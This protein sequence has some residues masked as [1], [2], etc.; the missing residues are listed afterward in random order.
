MIFLGIGLLLYSFFCPVL[1]LDRL[2]CSVG[3]N[4]EE[5]EQLQV[6][7]SAADEYYLKETRKKKPDT[8]HDMVFLSIY[9][10]FSVDQTLFFGIFQWF[11]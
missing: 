4:N 5:S 10:L 6:K 1:V 3:F 7:R 9:L 2:L 11:S 8:G